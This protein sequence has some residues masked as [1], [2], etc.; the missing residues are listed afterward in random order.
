M[1][2]GEKQADIEEWRL[3]VKERADIL[4]K[5]KASRGDIGRRTAFGESAADDGSIF[6][7][8]VVGLA[9]SLLIAPDRARNSSR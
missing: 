7:A 2:G 6:A 4:P 1:V 9:L 8:G 3:T 5:R